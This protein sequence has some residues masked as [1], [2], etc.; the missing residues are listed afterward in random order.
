MCRLLT[1][2]FVAVSVKRKRVGWV[3]DKAVKA[4]ST[5][6]SQFKHNFYRSRASLN[7]QIRLVQENSFQE[8]AHK[9]WVIVHNCN[10]EE[11]A[12]TLVWTSSMDSP[13]CRSDA[14]R[15]SY[16]ESMRRAEVCQQNQQRSDLISRKSQLGQQHCGNPATLRSRA[17]W[18]LYSSRSIRLSHISFHS[19]RVRENLRVQTLAENSKRPNVRVS[20]AAG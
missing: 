10:N 9:Q 19:T 2:E 16:K 11:H 12:R 17:Q 3:F 8:A 13:M 4:T 20:L 14:S 7:L 1:V 15:N 18:N 6:T 5:R